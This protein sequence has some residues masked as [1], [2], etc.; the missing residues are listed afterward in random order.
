MSRVKLQRKKIIIGA[1]LVVLIGVV[2]AANIMKSQNIGWLGRGD[3]I[4]VEARAVEKGAISSTVVASGIAELAHDRDIYLE[5]SV[6]VRRV[7]VEPFDQVSA[8]QQLMEL[9]LDSLYIQL[10]KEQVSLQIQ[11]LNG[12]QSSG[13]GDASAL[14]DLESARLLAE[15]ELRSAR[16]N[17]DEAEANLERT[18]SLYRAGAASKVE[19]EAAR[20]KA[21]DA[22]IALE[23][24]QIRAANA[25]N[26]EN[27]QRD[28]HDA[29][30]R[31][32]SLRIAELEMQI[33]RAEEA[34]FSP[35]DG[36]VTAVNI[37]D[38]EMG[39][40]ASPA[41]VIGD[42]SSLRIRANVNEAD[43]NSVKAGQKVTI[44][45]DAFAEGMEIQGMV[46]S[47]AL[48]ARDHET[49]TGREK[50][51][52]TLIALER[53]ELALQVLSPGQNVDC[54]I[55]TVSSDNAIICSYDMILD[56]RDGQRYVFVVNTEDQKVRK[57]YVTLGIISELDAEITDGLSEGDMVVMN[58]PPNLKE[59]SLVR[60]V[61]SVTEG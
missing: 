47:V 33:D 1:L 8:G 32:A 36:I 48:S 25:L 41:I 61:E 29:N 54:D 38:G 45:S 26:S 12:Q 9:D 15:N 44:T 10:E 57:Q 53:V 52:E 34:M 27:T 17:M 30:T 39:Q 4:E 16:L 5:S 20:K 11:E 51:F 7:L 23:N 3:A 46:S 2:A 24:A 49:T 43:K 55:M 37:R 58:P 56:D 21:D 35:S 13:P 60:I 6:K 59:D 28:L 40:S 18:E 42:F 19:L 14:G 50:I 31:A 22:G